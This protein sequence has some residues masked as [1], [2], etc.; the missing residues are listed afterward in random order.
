MPDLFPCFMHDLFVLQAYVPNNELELL[1]VIGAGGFGTVYRGVWREGLSRFAFDLPAQL[2]LNWLLL[3]YI[4]VRH[5]SC[6]CCHAD[7]Q[8]V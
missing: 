1:G 7:S 6:L 3:R 4:K 5:S 2:L 8:S